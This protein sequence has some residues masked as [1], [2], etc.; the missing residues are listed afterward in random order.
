MWGLAILAVLAS[1]V[2]L[3]VTASQRV[4]GSMTGAVQGGL[5]GAESFGSVRFLTAVAFP[6]ELAQA[7]SVNACAVSRAVL[8][9]TGLLFTEP[10]GPAVIATALSAVPAV[11]VSVAIWHLADIRRSIA[12]GSFPALVAMAAAAREYP[13]PATQYWTHR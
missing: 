1:P 3:A 2:R 5:A 4:P 10:T 8:V 9:R 7:V 13:V 11:P 6:A 12:I